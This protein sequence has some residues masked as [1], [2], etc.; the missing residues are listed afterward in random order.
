VSNFA[1]GNL[2][3]DFVATVSE[4]GT[5]A[6]ERLTEPARLA[7]WLVRSG[8]LDKAPVVTDADLAAAL[9]LREALFRV[10]AALIDGDV[11][12]RSALARVNAAATGPLPSVHVTTA[13][14]V[15][16]SGDVS[17]AMT[18]VARDGLELFDRSDPAVLKWCAD[19]ACTRPFLDRSRGAR[20]R[21][22][23]MA[24]CG[25]RAKAAAYRARLRA[26]DS[27]RLCPETTPQK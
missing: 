4:R 2:A 6:L 15:H 3:L 17:A 21:W 18:A 13:G 12:P 1:G 22:C 16:R 20:R 27:V 26:G 8:V 24:G 19:Q 25:D 23:D 9:G 11:L 5:T 10:V 7:E 14:K